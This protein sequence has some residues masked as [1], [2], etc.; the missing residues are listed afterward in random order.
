MIAIIIEIISD[1]LL[2]V[3]SYKVFYNFSD[4]VDI[5]F[6]KKE[7]KLGWR[8]FGGQDICFRGKHPFVKVS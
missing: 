1:L 5:S 2:F 3:K 8:V 7:L 4:R 6:V